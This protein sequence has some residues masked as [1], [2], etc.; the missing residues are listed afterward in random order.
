MDSHRK[1]VKTGSTAEEYSDAKLC[2]QRIYSGRGGGVTRL[3]VG[4]AVTVTHVV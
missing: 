1:D 3:N 4:V 2:G